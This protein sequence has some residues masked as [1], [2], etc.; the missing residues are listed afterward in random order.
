MDN[1]GEDTSWG[2]YR[3][4]VISELERLTRSI[5][6]LH[7]KID[8]SLNKEITDMKVRLATVEV[9]IGL[10]GTLTGVV[11]SLAT[12]LVKYLVQK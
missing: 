3:K 4:L 6:E 9:K 12:E 2:Q 8:A 10:I 5:Q 1:G 11:G 7:G